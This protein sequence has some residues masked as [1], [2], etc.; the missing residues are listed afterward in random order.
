MNFQQEEGNALYLPEE[1]RAR[2]AQKLLLSSD[3]PSAPE[4]T[5]EW[6]SEARRRATELD[7]GVVQPIF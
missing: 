6:L 4:N 2:L 3:S 7:A 1:D 5:E